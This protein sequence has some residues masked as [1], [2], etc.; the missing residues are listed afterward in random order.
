[1][2]S[3]AA[4]HGVVAVRRGARA[5][6]RSMRVVSSFRAAH[7]TRGA[8]RNQ[9]TRAASLVSCR[10][11]RASC[12]EFARNIWREYLLSRC[13]GLPDLK[14]P[15]SNIPLDASGEAWP[16]DPS[17]RRDQSKCCNDK[18]K[19]VGKDRSTDS[20]TNKRYTMED[21]WL[22]QALVSMEGILAGT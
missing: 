22:T 12:H 21:C 8:K 15:F 18:T 6:H 1:M 16:S 10:A 9:N 14:L 5:R 19:G 3:N 20:W 17:I 2:T 13:G 11:K 7:L 4:V